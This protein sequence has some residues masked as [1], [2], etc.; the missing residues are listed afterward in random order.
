MKKFDRKKHPKESEFDAISV[1]IQIRKNK[2]VTLQ[3]VCDLFRET[4]WVEMFD[5]SRNTC[6]RGNEIVCTFRVWFSKYKS[7]W[8]L[9]T[10]RYHNLEK[11]DV[12]PDGCDLYGPEKL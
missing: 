6:V 12:T 4:D 11:Q 3:A 1:R 9:K 2:S 10:G 5:N 7:V 8:N